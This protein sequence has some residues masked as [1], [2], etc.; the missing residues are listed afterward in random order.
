M[1]AERSVTGK[2]VVEC[3]C[4][5]GRLAGFVGERDEGHPQVPGGQGAQLI[6][7]S[8]G[9]AAIIGHR[10][11][12][13][14]VVGEPPQRTETRRQPMATP[15][16]YDP[17]S[18]SGSCIV[19]AHHSRPRSRWTTVTSAAPSRSRDEISSA[20]TTL[21]CFPPVHPTAIVT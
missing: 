16:G 3:R 14:E 1:P 18:G 20:M 13:G 6:S 11:H 12:R 10:H 9:R 7:Q 4:P 2:A 21:R 8:A 17:W 5:V 19:A 15:E